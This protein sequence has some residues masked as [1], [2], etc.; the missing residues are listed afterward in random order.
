[1]VFTVVSL[2]E[3]GENL[4]HTLQGKNLDDGLYVSRPEGFVAQVSP[5]HLSQPCCLALEFRREALD[6]LPRWR[7]RG[8]R[9]DGRFCRQGDR[10]EKK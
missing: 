5:Y 10:G 8:L 2:D 1:M 6:S 3:V 7:R 4:N 9:V